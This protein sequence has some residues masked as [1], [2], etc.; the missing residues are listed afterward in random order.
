M[1]DVGDVHNDKSELGTAQHAQADEQAPSAGHTAGISR[2]Q[3]GGGYLADQNSNGQGEGMRDDRDEDIP[4]ENQLRAQHDK[5]NRTDPG[6]SDVVYEPLGVFV[7]M[8]SMLGSLE[9]E[10]LFT[11][12]EAEVA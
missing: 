7:R 11:H 12:D 9:G 3:P 1:L 4:I 2:R 5:K 6:K 8:R 10:V